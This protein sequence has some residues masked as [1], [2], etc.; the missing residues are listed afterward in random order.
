MDTQTFCARLKYS[1]YTDN[2]QI[3]AK[4]KKALQFIARMATGEKV[5]PCKDNANGMRIITCI[6][7]ICKWTHI[8]MELKSD[9][10]G[11]VG[12][13]CYIPIMDIEKLKGVDFTAI[14]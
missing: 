11:S 2:G 14:K 4:Y 9:T 7:D 1:A 6:F 5:Y 13:Y 12:L 10:R 3:Q 8:N